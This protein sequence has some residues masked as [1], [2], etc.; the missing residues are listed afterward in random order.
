MKMKIDSLMVSPGA[1]IYYDA[2]FRNVLEDHMTYLRQHSSTA[3]IDVEAT[4]AIKYQ[5]DLFGLLREYRVPEQ[6][7]WLT[8]RMNNMTSPT[9]AT[10]DISS[11]LVPDHTEVG[12][13]AQAHQTTRRI[14]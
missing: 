13:I 11:L 2:D 9:D 10:A 4:K 5:F 8:M 7:H 12:R 6:L 14:A 3:Q 1:S